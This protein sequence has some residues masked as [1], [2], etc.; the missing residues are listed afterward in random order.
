MVL[1]DAEEAGP[2]NVCSRCGRECE[3]LELSTCPI[4]GRRYCNY[5]GYRVGSRTYC[6]RPCGDSF[7]FGGDV[8]EDGL[9]ED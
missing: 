5:C 8:D 2:Q 9:A 6:G 7:F 4:C 1:Q 3:P